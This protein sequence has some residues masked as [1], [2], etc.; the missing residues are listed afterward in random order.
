M[1]QK[2][3]DAVYEHLPEL[4]KGARPSASLNKGETLERMADALRLPPLEER[5]AK[6]DKEQKET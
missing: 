1:P 2:T 3:L 5:H 4:P 6:L